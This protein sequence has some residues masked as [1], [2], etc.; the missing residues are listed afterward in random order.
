MSRAQERELVRRREQLLVRSAQLRSR[1]AQ[2]LRILGTPLALADQ[3]ATAARWLIRNPQWPLG[4]LVVW[5]VFRP[6]RAL[7]WAARL[8]WFWVVGRRVRRI[9]MLAPQLRR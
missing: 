7:R 3:T 9:L 2:E 6:R 8:S 1:F 4:A 5:V